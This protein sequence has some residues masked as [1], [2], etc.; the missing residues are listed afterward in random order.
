[1]GARPS[2]AQD[3]GAIYNDQGQLDM[4][5][6]VLQ[7]SS[8]TPQCKLLRQLDHSALSTVAD[9]WARRSS[10]A[11]YGGAIYNNQGQLDM[12]SC[13]LESSSADVM[14]CSRALAPQPLPQRSASA[15][16]R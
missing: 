3:G 1:M 4:T 6:C 2:V 14:R 12:T 7:N 8:A 5:N 13:V 11:Q 10:G 9:Q 15:R 16:R